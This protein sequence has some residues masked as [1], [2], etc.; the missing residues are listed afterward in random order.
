MNIILTRNEGI[1][2]S[3]KKMNIILTSAKANLFFLLFKTS[4]VTRPS[5][6]ILSEIV[7]LVNEKC[8]LV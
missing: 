2:I 5:D 1:L 7:L 8:Y 4:G 3:V 6:R